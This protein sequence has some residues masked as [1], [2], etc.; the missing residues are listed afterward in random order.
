[1]VAC[2]GVLMVEVVRGSQVQDMFFGESCLDWLRG[3]EGWLKDF[4]PN[5]S[6]S[7]EVAIECDGEAM[8]EQFVRGI[9][10]SVLDMLNL[11]CLL[12]LEVEFS[13]V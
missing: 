4:C 2:A 5:F 10:S 8:G 13:A 1:M 6:L 7:S 11:R 9:R 12:G 3:G